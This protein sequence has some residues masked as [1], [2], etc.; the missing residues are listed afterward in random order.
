MRMLRPTKPLHLPQVSNNQAEHIL[1]YHQVGKH[2]VIAALHSVYQIMHWFTHVR[3]SLAPLMIIRKSS[4][5]VYACT[6]A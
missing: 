2:T 5:P 1:P 3:Q 6:A 4:D